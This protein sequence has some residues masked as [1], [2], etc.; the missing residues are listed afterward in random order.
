VRIEAQ[1]A[2]LPQQTL[3][4]KR[5]H[6]RRAVESPIHEVDHE[7]RGLNHQSLPYLLGASHQLHLVTGRRERALHLRAEQ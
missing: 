6:E 2:R 5:F 3:G 4:R 1:R 7:H